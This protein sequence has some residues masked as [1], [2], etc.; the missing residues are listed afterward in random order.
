M[1]KILI[2]ETKLK[3]LEENMDKESKQLIQIKEIW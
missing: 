3:H 1:K 2:C